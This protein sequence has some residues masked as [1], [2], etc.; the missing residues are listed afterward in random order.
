MKK[1]GLIIVLLTLMSQGVS[2]QEI[3]TLKKCI[4]YAV[5]NNHT[6]Q[7]SKLDRDKA[8]QARREITGALLPQINGSGSMTYNIQKTT[9]AMP[10]FMNDMLPEQM[11]DPNAPKYMT[12]TMGMN[13]AANIGASLMQQVLNFSLFNAVDISKSVQ[14]MADIGYEIGTDDVIAQTATIFYNIQVLGYALDQ[15]DTSLNLMDKTIRM[16]EVNRADDIVRQVDLDRIKVTKANL[17]TQKDNIRQ[18]R[19]VQK[20][21]LK[22][23]MGFDMN[24]DIEIQRIDIR[25]MEEIATTLPNTQFNVSALLPYRLIREKTQLTTLQHRSAKYETLPTLTFVANYAQNFMS[26][27]FFRGETYH[28]FPVSML[29]L[30]LKVPIFSGLSKRA[31]VKQADIEISKASQDELQLEQSL[32]MGHANAMMQLENS[33]KNIIVQRGNKQLAEDVYN[34]T[35]NNFKEGICPLS[36]VLNASSSLIQSQISYVEALNNY[37]KAYIDIKKADGTIRD[38]VK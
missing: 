19:D 9:F 12:I 8:V 6:L 34:V 22:L 36:D 25:T 29:S 38:I 31:K 17:E 14:K 33:L 35:D 11:R 28:R 30:N 7:K 32:A 16:M 10:N 1:T 23:Q 27:E 37:M 2:G 18:A 15:F 3:F 5:E 21:L 4:D 26:D 13:Y 24:D 20:N